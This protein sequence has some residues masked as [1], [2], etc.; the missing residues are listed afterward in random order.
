[1]FKQTFGDLVRTLREESRFRNPDGRKTTQ[2][3]LAQELLVILD[4]TPNKLSKDQIQNVIARIEQGV[5][6]NI[7]PDMLSALAQVFKLTTMEYVQ[8]GQA[9]AQLKAPQ[10]NYVDTPNLE[11]ILN[12]L[13]NQVQE[14]KCPVMILDSHGDIVIFNHAMMNFYGQ[15]ITTLSQTPTLNL[16]IAMFGLNHTS[17]RDSYFE[18][19]MIQNIKF[20]RSNSMLDRC[21]P[22]FDQLLTYLAKTYPKFTY[23]WQAA[24]DSDNDVISLTNSYEHQHKEFGYI[25]YV[26][27][28]SYIITSRGYLYSLN[29][30]D[31]DDSTRKAFD[32][33]SNNKVSYRNP[34]WPKCKDQADIIFQ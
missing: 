31:I 17:V 10:L 14:A 11:V 20:I 7:D 25:R 13:G 9:Y 30:S 8:F 3:E 1:M 32:S 2:A 16:L 21:S 26:N 34:N 23:Y 18:K 27:N 5:R 28:V 12:E 15:S 4:S 29:Y 24:Y 33:L 19:R 22:Y 6:R